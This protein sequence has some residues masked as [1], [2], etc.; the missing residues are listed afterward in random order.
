[1]LFFDAAETFL[2]RLFICL[3]PRLF[4]QM[5]DGVNEEAACATSWVKNCFADSRIYLLD[6]ESIS[7]N[8][9]RS[10]DALK[11]MPLILLITCRIKVPFFM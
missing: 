11:S 9:W 4:A 7:P 6:N 1:M 10:A 8:M 2:N 5:L 3:S